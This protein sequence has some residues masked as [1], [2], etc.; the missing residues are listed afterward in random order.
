MI[1]MR[2]RTATIVALA[3]LGLAVPVMAAAEPVATSVLSH[4][5]ARGDILAA[6]DF[7]AQPRPPG[8][9]IG[10]IAPDVA[11]GREAAR[12]L[13]AGAVVRAGDV[14]A[15]RLVRRGDPVTINLRS[16]GLVIA[17][18]GRAL[19]AGGMGDLVRVVAQSTNRTFDATVEGSGAVHV[20]LP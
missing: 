2:F 12:N 20:P 9:A 15:P 5:V 18:T 17:T 1:A 11:A 10:A 19:S 6:T 16:R 8:Y 13:V 4:A 14:V 7:E 3:G